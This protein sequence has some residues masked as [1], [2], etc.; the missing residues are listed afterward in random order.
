MATATANAAQWK[1]KVGRVR[2]ASLTLI[3]R[4]AYQKQAALT[5]SLPAKNSAVVKAFLRSGG[6]ASISSASRGVPSTCVS[7][8]NSGSTFLRLR[9]VRQLPGHIAL[10]YKS[11]RFHSSGQAGPAAANLGSN[12]SRRTVPDRRRDDL[13][14]DTAREDRAVGGRAGAAARARRAAVPARR[15]RQRRKLQPRSERFQETVRHRSLQPDR[16][17]FRVDRAHQRRG[18]GQRL[19]RLAGDQPA[20]WR[21]RNSDIFG[22]RAAT[23]SAT[24]APILSAR[25]TSRRNAPPRCS[26]SSARIPDTPRDMATWSSSSRR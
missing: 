11:R 18:L 1:S 3:W 4:S 20:R 25:S 6:D 17:R 22:R 9:L 5:I 13:Q 24:S 12:E 14:A 10:G 26:G 19:R 21:R 23:P 2:T 15:R 7:M 16:Q 8:W